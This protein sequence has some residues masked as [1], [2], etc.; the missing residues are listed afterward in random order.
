MINHANNYDEIDK[1][2]PMCQ[3]VPKFVICV[4]RFLVVGHLCVCIKKLSK[5]VKMTHYANI[6]GENIPKF[7]KLVNTV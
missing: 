5:Y 3:G 6:S 4:N 2:K 7:W 1:N